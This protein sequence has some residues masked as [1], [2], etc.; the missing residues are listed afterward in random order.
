MQRSVE[1]RSGGQV[2]VSMSVDLF[3]LDEDDHKFVNG[4]VK[5]IKEYGERRALVIA[6]ETNDA[7]AINDAVDEEID[8]AEEAK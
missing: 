6:V 1:L 7:A 8:D 4:L 5:A 3:S 2:T